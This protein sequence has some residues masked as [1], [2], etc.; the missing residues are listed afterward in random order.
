MPR[1]MTRSITAPNSGAMHEDH[2]DDRRHTGTPQATL[3]L[4]V[5]ERGHH[6][7]RPVGE[8]ED[9]RGGVG[10]HQPDGRDGVDGGRR[11]P[12]DG[13]GEELVHLCVQR[14]LGCARDHAVPSGGLGPGPDRLRR[15]GRVD[16]AL[17]PR[18]AGTSTIAV[19]GAV[20]PVGVVALAADLGVEALEVAVLGD[21]SSMPHSGGAVAPGAGSVGTW[22]PPAVQSST[23]AA[24]L[25]H[26]APGRARCRWPR[27]SRWP[28]WRTA[29]RPRC[30]ACPAAPACRR[31]RTA[32]GCPGTAGSPATRR[33]P[34]TG[35]RPCGPGCP[36]P[37][38]RRR[39]RPVG[40]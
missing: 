25:E 38:R 30:S 36:R 14:C 15:A 24:C 16:D 35:G 40:S 26:A 21:L 10:D 34:R 5:G 9:A 6:P 33:P 19:L 23:A 8:V 18:S 31:A 22:R 13:E 32:R 12:G 37:R 11:Q 3:H 2:D 20:E 39:R 28:R 7:E 29:A 4:P 1:M 17:R 27:R